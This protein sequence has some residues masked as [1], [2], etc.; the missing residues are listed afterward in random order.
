MQRL[1]LL[2][3]L[4]AMLSACSWHWRDIA[5]DEFGCDGESLSWEE[6]EQLGTDCHMVGDNGECLEQGSVTCVYGT[7][8]LTCNA[9]GDAPWTTTLQ[10]LPPDYCE[11]GYDINC[12]GLYYDGC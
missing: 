6:Y 12:N 5:T 4:A 1:F 11:A 10:R 7:A 3:A 8:I 9:W 2:A